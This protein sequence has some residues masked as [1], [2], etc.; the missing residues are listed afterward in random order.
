MATT[1]NK[2]EELKQ[3]FKDFLDKETLKLSDSISTSN[4]DWVV[5]GFID[6]A[7]NIYTISIDTNV[8]PLMLFSFLR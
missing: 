2:K 7:K 6:V 4:G 8:I 3:S 1:H 5:K